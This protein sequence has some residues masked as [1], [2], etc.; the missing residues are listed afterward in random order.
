MN[1]GE[2]EVVFHHQLGQALAQWAYVEG[3]IQRIVIQCVP[4]PSRPAV[5]AAYVSIESF[6]SKLRFCDNLVAATYGKAWPHIE[7]WTAA[8]K[9]ATR[10]ASKRN[11]LAHGIKHLYANNVVARRWTLVDQRPV[12]GKIPHLTGKCPP[13][14][15]LG[16]IDIAKIRHEFHALTTDL[17]N[18]FE[19]L[20][21]RREPFPEG[22]E[23]AT[24][25]PTIR[26][27]RNQIRAEVGLPPLPERR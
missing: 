21:G 18:V 20:G 15:A 14:G 8:N 9:E 1:L 25:R 27:L 13:S 26:L 11:L 7:R 22:I 4:L 17:L 23:P 2:E 16:M 10:L 12:D 5:A 19:L 3:Q 24:Y 6:Y